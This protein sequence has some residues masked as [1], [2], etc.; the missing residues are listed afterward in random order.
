MLEDVQHLLYSSKRTIFALKLMPR[1]I[2]LN[3]P[4]TLKDSGFL[5]C[6]FCYLKISGDLVG[7]FL[8]TKTSTA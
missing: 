8:K 3:S 6:F 4:S 1:G 7:I 2:V 5:V